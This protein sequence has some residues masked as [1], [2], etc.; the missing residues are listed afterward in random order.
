MTDDFLAREND[1]LGGTFSSSAGGRLSGNT[2]EIDLDRAAS[3]FPD[4]DLDGDIP[5]IPQRT[6]SNKDGNFGFS[7]NSLISPPA[8]PDVKITGDD[9]IDK[10]ESAFPDLEPIPQVTRAFSVIMTPWLTFMPANLLSTTSSTECIFQRPGLCPS[11]P[12][13]CWIF[14][15]HSASAN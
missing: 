1:F 2:D 10:F 5:P 8:Q 12:A 7:M 11:P 3:A 13:L 14:H 4:I 9:E 6:T 15:T